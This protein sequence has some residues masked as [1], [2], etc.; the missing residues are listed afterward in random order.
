MASS[1]THVPQL[2]TQQAQ[3]DVII[4][5]LLD[6]ASPAMLFGRNFATTSGLTWG[7]LGGVLDVAGTPTPIANGTVTLAASATNYVEATTAGAVSVNQSAFTNGRIPLY[8]VITGANSA[9][10]WTDHRTGQGSATTGAGSV[11]IQVACSDL[12]T[13]LEAGTSKAYFRMPYAMTLTEVRSSLL[14]AGSSG[15]VTVDINKNGSTILSTKLTID[16]GEKTSETASSA[17]VVSDDDLADDDE[18]TIDIDGVGSGSILP[19]GLI[20]TLIGVY[21]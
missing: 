21:A 3:P 16:A 18:I 13:D 14:R 7:Y 1:A 12:M 10:S 17:A 5:A 20:V 6:A 11:V 4:N 15:V 2:A 9:T 19:R 8:T